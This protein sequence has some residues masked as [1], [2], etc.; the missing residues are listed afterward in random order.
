MYL[1]AIK[2]L[3]LIFFNTKNLVFSF[4]YITFAD[5]VRQMGY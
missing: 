3:P 4:K 2:W 1:R 5:R